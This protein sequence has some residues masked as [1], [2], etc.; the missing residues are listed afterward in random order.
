MITLKKLFTDK[1][2]NRPYCSDNL[3]YGLAIRNKLIAKEKK[4]IQANQP[5]MVNWLCFDIDY[6]GVLE[7]TFEEKFLPAP[8]F[9]IENPINKHSHLI[10]GLVSGVCSSSHAKHHPLRYLASVEYSLRKELKADF[11]FSGL[12]IKNPLHEAWNTYEIEKK[13]WDLS[14]LADYLTLP[15]KLPQ[16]AQL[17]GLGRNCTL[18]EL[19]RK[20]AY[21]QITLFRTNSTKEIFHQSIL[22]YIQTQ[23]TS[24][25]QPL[26]FNECRSIAKSISNWTWKNYR[27]RMDDASWKEYVDKTH[28]SEIQSRRGKKSGEVRYEGSN[29][30]LK[31]WKKLSI[32]RAWYYRQKQAEKVLLEK[33]LV[34]N[35]GEMSFSRLEPISDNSNLKN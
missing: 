2:A 11:G 19:A 29:E 5:F 20:F 1:L 34:E 27:Q 13:L 4:Y 21:A 24:F 8:N 23:N 31:P 12:I 15:K 7:T 33:T 28:T 10:Y 30:Q 6:P 14:D 25:P 16:K 32:S 22:G 35:T 17:V 26:Q 9:L 3:D 18:F